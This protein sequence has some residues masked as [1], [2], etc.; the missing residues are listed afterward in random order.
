MKLILAATLLFFLTNCSFDNKSSIWENADNT[1]KNKKKDIFKDFK[2]ISSSNNYYNK[3][4]ALN[5]DVILST[6][7][8][9]LNLDWNDIFYQKNNNF[10]NFQYNDLDE[11]SFKSKKLSRYLLNEHKLYENGNAIVCDVKGNI[12]VYSIIDGNVIAKFNFYK[13]EYKKIKK[14]LNII[15]EDNIIFVAD[16]LG[17]FYAYNYINNKVIWAKNFK[18]PFSSNLK[19][20]KNLIVVSNQ[21]NHLYFVNKLNGDL[22]KLIPTEETPIKNEFS[23]NL[24]IGNVN[25]LLFLNSFGSLYSIDLNKLNINWFNNYNQTLNISPSNIFFG[26]TVINNKDVIVVSSNKNTFLVDLKS[27]SLVRKFNFSSAIK[28]IIIKNLVFLITRNNFLITIDLERK[29]ILYSLD[30]NEIQD[31]KI[32]NFSPNLFK[33]IMILNSKIFIFLNN[34]KILTF[35]VNGKFIEVRKLKSKI[36]SHPIIIEKSILYIDK[37]NKLVVLN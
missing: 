14:K 33:E 7:K 24:S 12:I 25:N 21:T 29:K 1:F 23:N 34:S 11:I 15:I 8:P 10:E 13:K 37:K 35:D 30:F 5:Q 27:G 16:N 18:I 28:P 32:K 4:I 22:V 9:I 31:L 19:I 36:H 2:K 26:S 3:K 6:S 17:Y 20:F